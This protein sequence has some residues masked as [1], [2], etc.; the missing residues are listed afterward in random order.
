MEPIYCHIRIKGH[1]SDHWD[2]WLGGLTIDNQPDGEAVL[3]GSLPDHTALYGVLSQMR[4]LG[5][6]LVSLACADLDAGCAAA[7]N[8]DPRRIRGN[9]VLDTAQGKGTQNG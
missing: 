6:Q 4:D 1:L 3:S 8:R 9:D 5:L 2:D 7:G